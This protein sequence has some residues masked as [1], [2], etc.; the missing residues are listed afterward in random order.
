MV[1]AWHG[2]GM[3]SVNQTRPHCVNQMGKTHFKPIAARHGRGTTWARHAMCESA[4][5][6]LL[7]RMIDLVILI[8]VCQ[9]LSAV[10]CCVLHCEPKCDVPKWTVTT[11]L[12]R[13]LLFFHIAPIS[14][15]GCCVYMI[16]KWLCVCPPLR[17]RKCN[18][19]GVLGWVHTCNV[20]AYRNTVS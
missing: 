19:S 2:H 16:Q 8:K 9:N 1:I 11:F 7:C 15:F 6:G 4:F 18:A 5:K 20:T 10:Q 12:S 17:F 14:C 3:A 13:I